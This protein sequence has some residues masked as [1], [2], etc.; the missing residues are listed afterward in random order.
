MRPSV[1]IFYSNIFAQNKMW[2]KYGTKNVK[3]PAEAII[4]NIYI[5]HIYIQYI[6]IAEL[7]HLVFM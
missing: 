1:R 5:L 2:H 7:S 3:I 4:Y 6:Y